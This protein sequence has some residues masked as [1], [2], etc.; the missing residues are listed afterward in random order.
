MTGTRCLT[1]ECAIVL[2]GLVLTVLR[3]YGP[4]GVSNASAYSMNYT[5]VA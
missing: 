3:S 5:F 4:V 1:R 2:P